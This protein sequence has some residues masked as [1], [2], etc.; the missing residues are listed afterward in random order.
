[1]K[2]LLI[3]LVWLISGVFTAEAQ[4][5]EMMQETLTDDLVNYATAKTIKKFTGPPE[6]SMLKSSGS[7]KTVFKIISENL[8]EEA[9]LALNYAVEIWEGFFVSTVPVNVFV[10]LEPL[11]GNI[12][13]K[14]RPAS[15]FMNFEGALHENVYYPVALAEK[16][17]G[18]DMNPENHDIICSFNQNLPWYFGIDGNTPE[19]HY[20]FVTAV[21]HEIAHGLGFS[22]FFKDDG[23]EGF[24][25]NGNHLPSIYDLYVFDANNQQLANSTL[26]PCPSALL[27]NALVSG[28]LRFLT[29]TGNEKKARFPEVYS[30]PYWNDCASIYHLADCEGLM[31]PFAAKGLA[32]HHPGN[33]VL[34]I[35]NE[36]GWSAPVFDFQ[37][38][39]DFEEPC[40]ELPVAIEIFSGD[41]ANNFSVNFIFSNNN[42][43]TSKSIK[44]IRNESSGQFK[45]NIPLNYSAGKI[46]Y[47]FET[48]TANENIYK[49]PHA[50]PDKCL[51]FKIG[52]D[53]IPPVIAHNPQ[54]LLPENADFYMIN[55]LAKDNLGINSVI[56]EY[57]LNGVLQSP[58]DLKLTGNENYS[59]KLQL[60]NEQFSNG[61][62]EYR[63]VAEDKSAA[64]NKKHLP[65]AG[66]YS[67]SFFQSFEPVKSLSSDFESGSSIFAV[68]DFN[69]SRIVGFSDNVLHTLHPYPVSALKD[70]KYNLIAQLKYPIILQEDGE[71]RFDEVVLVEPGEK[72]T[73]FSE[74]FFWDFVVVEGS[75]DKGSTWIPFLPGYDSGAHENWETA[76]VNS[77]VN[78]KSQAVGSQNMFLQNVIRLTENTG[79]YAGDTVLFRFRLASDNSLNGWGWAIDNLEIQ[80]TLATDSDL[81]V[82][83]SIHAYPNPFFN[84]FFVDFSAIENLGQIH[85]IVTDIIG[86]TVYKKDNISFFGNPESIELPGVSSGIYLLKITDGKKELFAG[87]MI[88]K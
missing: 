36:I 16:L 88:K 2:R 44:L 5:S 11:D 41:V 37:P 42:F 1:M 35:L 24:I 84:K 22:G 63:I 66:F 83:K 50:A 52:P 14:S 61:K 65:S 4:K 67:V 49:F 8:T 17:S 86:K 59:G 15:F 78:N 39:K 43:E 25:N 87:K 85:I 64:G 51:S 69:I 82:Q 80:T 45:A 70:E 74:D 38:L 40:A 34:A 13:A 46:E 79:F 73:E 77:T 76:F 47:Y 72:G 33:E 62:L 30:P 6:K 60:S 54:K 57:K 20:D 81:I 56:V 23:T 55:A 26:F 3:I 19:T 58:I 32:I 75:K 48:K 68:A 31:K 9:I 28:D 21:L 10:K 27:H 29:S 7:G 12:V 53:Y 18:K 71:M